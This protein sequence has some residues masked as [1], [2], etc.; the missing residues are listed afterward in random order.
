ML[1]GTVP[2][3]QYFNL[4]GGEKKSAKGVTKLAQRQLTH[5]KFKE[6]LSSGRL[7]RTQMHRIASSSHQLHTLTNNKVSLNAFDDKRYILEHGIDTLSFGHIN[8]VD[9]RFFDEDDNFDNE[10]LSS[11]SSGEL[12]EME[13]TVETNT[14][15][16]EIS[17]PGFVRTTA[18]TESDIDSDEIADENEIEEERPVYN[19]FIDYEAIESD[20]YLTKQCAILFAI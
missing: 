13:T 3:S 9:D 11:W 5:E 20:S 16:A 2:N 12:Y 18:I 6:T 17:N 4:D 7:I 14:D 19:P 8:F 10:S 15:N 1:V